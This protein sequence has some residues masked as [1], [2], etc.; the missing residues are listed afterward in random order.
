M[1][2]RHPSWFLGLSLI[3][4]LL[5]A[6]E[7]GGGEHVQ[8]QA[9]NVIQQQNRPT[10][11]TFAFA[12]TETSEALGYSWPM[13]E[14][15]EDE[16]GAVSVAITPLNLNEAGP[17]LEFQVALNTH[18]IDL[19][20]DLALLATL[21]TDTGLVVSAELWDAPH[22][23]HHVTGT[24]FFPAQQENKSILDGATE[25]TLTIRDVDSVD[26]VFRWQQ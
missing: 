6:C 18:S 16:Q 26:R 11:T 23:G 13:N 8:A 24:L 19:S 2:I 10:E 5:V 17:T 7:G 1:A 25:L 22:S 14:T 9:P 20:M 15:Q 12:P 21:A 3:S 4:L